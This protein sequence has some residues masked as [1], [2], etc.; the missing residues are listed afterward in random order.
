MILVSTRKRSVV[1]A[2]CWRECSDSVVLVLVQC[3]HTSVV[4]VRVQ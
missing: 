4:L 3:S 2:W 1:I